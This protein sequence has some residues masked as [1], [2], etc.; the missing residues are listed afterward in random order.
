MKSAQ[1]PVPTAT[2]K[3][4]REPARL[5]PSALAQL[6]QDE[7]QAGRYALG[8]RMPTELELQQRH[9]VSRY[10]VRAAL[11]QLKNSGMV[12]ARAGIGHAVLAAEPVR[13]RYMHGSTT[14]EELVQS[15]G[16]T[17]H[18]VQAS[19]RRADADVAERTGFALG[20]QVVEVTALRTKL[21]DDAP[22]ALLMLTLRADHAMM[23][24]YMEGETAPFHIVLEQRY[25]VRID[26]VQQR[27]V[28]VQAD[29]AQARLLRAATRQPCL[30]IAR[31]F[32]DEQGELLFC[33]IGL[34]PSDRFSHDTVFKVR[35]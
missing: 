15:I 29:A 8:G 12:S 32:L 22:T 31:R 18:V 17:L 21:G 26:A 30:R 1:P 28:A 2:V 35:R 33:S 6:L 5:S 34:Y 27:I 25:G 20:A 24:R 7:I 9:G 3:P 23:V 14:L 16:T 11:Q 10:C 13:D 19:E 4:W